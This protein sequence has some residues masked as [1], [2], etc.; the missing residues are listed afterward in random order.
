MNISGIRRH[1]AGWREW[2]MNPIV[3]KELRQAV[4]SWAVTGMMLLFLAGLFIIS[5][6]FFVTGADSDPDEQMGSALFTAFAVVLAIASIFFIPLYMGIRVAAERQENNPDLFYVSTLS[7]ARI[8][9][10]KFLCGAYMVVLFFSA[11]MP[12]MAFTNLLRGVDLPTVFFILFYLFLTVCG[13]NMVAI[14]LGCLPVTRPFKVF[15]GIFGVIVSMYSIG[16][17]LSFTFRFMTLGIG[18]SMGGRDFWI[19]TFTAIAVYAAVTGLFYVMA[20]ALVS[21]PSS[22][23]ALPVRVYITAVW[24]LTG[25]LTVAWVKK[26]GHSDAIIV[27]L[28]SVF[29]LLMLSLVVVVSNSDTLSNRVRRAIPAAPWK[30]LVAFLFFNGAAGGLVWV[31]AMTAAS[32]LFSSKVSSVFPTYL[33]GHNEWL[34]QAAFAGYIFAYAM[35]A[36]FIHRTFFPRRPAK[37]AG[38]LTVFIIALCALTPSI[39]LFFLNQLTTFSIEHLELGNIINIFS[40]RDDGRL[41]IHF[42]FAMSLLA[43]TAV[44]NGRW[45]FKQLR[46]FVP[47]PKEAPPVIAYEPPPQIQPQP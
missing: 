12:F 20:V 16:A 31:A 46:N 35:A 45:F 24:L 19:G 26:T 10:G 23:R 43:V 3:V 30:R 47:A 8:I 29:Y 37:I 2:E 39:F 33:V 4:R 32:F 34:S 18:S 1:F 15:F 27:W 44:L 13:I 6:V 38:L 17:A 22:N 25:L 41:V 42:Y 28:N 9:L 7:P 21:P 5:A 40:M 36:M 14:F 11:C